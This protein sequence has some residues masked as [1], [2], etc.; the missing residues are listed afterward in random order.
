MSFYSVT[1]Y[2]N[3]R[4]E[5]LVRNAYQF[6]F[7]HTWYYHSTAAIG[8]AMLLVYEEKNDF[9]ALPLIRKY[10]ADGQIT[11]SSYA[12]PISNLNFALPDDGMQERFEEAL[13]QHLERERVTQVSIRLHPIIHKDFRPLRTGVLH[14]DHDSLLIDLTTSADQLGADFNN[15]VSQLRK[16]GYT[17]RRALAIYDVDNFADLYR[18]NMLRLL[19]D[20]YD[21]AWFRQMLRPSGFE[22]TLLLCCNRDEIAAGALLTFCNGIMQ[23]HV[24]ATNEKDLFNAPLRLVLSEATQL[25]KNMEMEHLVLNGL[26]HRPDALFAAKAIGP[27]TYPGFKTWNVHRE[28]MQADQPSRFGHLSIAV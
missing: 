22:S 4:W 11:M 10:T 27:D 8:D 25:G 17:V 16:K 2:D 1:I 21:K 28:S 14:K 3:M 9:I 7:Y 19:P 20:Q 12:G 18:H 13:L 24:A 15:H 5:R 23:V 6:D 26:A